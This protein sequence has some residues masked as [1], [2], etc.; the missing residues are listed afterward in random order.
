MARRLGAISFQVSTLEEFEIASCQ[1]TGSWTVKT[2]LRNE[3]LILPIVENRMMCAQVSKILS[4]YPMKEVLK[5][6][7]RDV[8]LYQMLLKEIR[9]IEGKLLFCKEEEE[10]YWKEE[11]ENRENKIMNVLRQSYLRVMIMNKMK[12]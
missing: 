10:C 1:I 2:K 9:F 11:L 6:T 5:H 8:W 4:W 3:V 12:L 7:I